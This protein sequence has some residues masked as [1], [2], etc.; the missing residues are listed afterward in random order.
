MNKRDDA[1]FLLSYR[2]FFKPVD[3]KGK[4]TIRAYFTDADEKEACSDEIFIDTGFAFGAGSHA[5]TQLCLEALVD[6]DLSGKTLIDVGTGSGILA[7]AAVKLGAQSV[8]A[9]D[10]DKMAIKSAVRNAQINGFSGRI[11]FEVAGMECLE[12]L[13]LHDY[14]V[15]NLTEEDFIKNSGRFLNA[16][17]NYLILGGFLSSKVKSIKRIFRVKRFK[18]AK[19]REKISWSC[20]E[21]EHVR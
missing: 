13:F 9:F 21:Y 5:T 1:P 3:I 18:L 17:A 6:Q 7:I 8:Y 19:E 15:A 12:D 20:L 16:P 10:V 11:T 4:L 2:D 14:L